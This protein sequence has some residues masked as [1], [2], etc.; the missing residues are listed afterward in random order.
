M[1]FAA[2]HIVLYNL[3]NYYST[4]LAILSVTFNCIQAVS[5]QF[6]INFVRHFNQVLADK[7]F[8]CQ[9]SAILNF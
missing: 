9:Y 8:I 1:R 5:N 6:Q 4:D 7:I 3:C 2:V